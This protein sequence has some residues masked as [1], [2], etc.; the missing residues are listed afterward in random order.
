M[1][2]LFH[3]STRCKFLTYGYC[4]CWLC[5]T[6][7]LSL[8]PS[9]LWTEW[10]DLLITQYHFWAASVCPIYHQISY[11]SPAENLSFS[12]SKLSR[13]L[14]IV[15][16]DFV[17]SH[18]LWKIADPV[19]SASA[20]K[21]SA[22]NVSSV[23]TSIAVGIMYCL[24]VS[25]CITMHLVTVSGVPSVR[26]SS[27]RVIPSVPLSFTRVKYSILWLVVEKTWPQRHHVPV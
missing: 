4:V 10:L 14:L 2:L 11:L 17:L 22:P 3:N 19:Y 13:Y 16:S 6:Q 1:A 12:S 7:L 5:F 9:M 23:A 8:I 20:K 24:S 25:L 18:L 27:P 21:E 15:C 26:M